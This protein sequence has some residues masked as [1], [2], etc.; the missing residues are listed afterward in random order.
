VSN[1]ENA[2][3]FDPAAVSG[4][5]TNWPGIGNSKLYKNNYGGL[6]NSEFID[7]ALNLMRETSSIHAMVLVYTNNSQQTINYTVAKNSVNTAYHKP[8]TSTGQQVYVLSE[9]LASTS[10]NIGITYTSY[11][12]VVN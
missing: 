7:Y 10:A 8:S 4:N 2:Y 1:T 9:H 3:I 12:F 11:S 5:G 6:S